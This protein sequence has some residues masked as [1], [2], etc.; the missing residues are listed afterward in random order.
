M[1]AFSG[2]A[3]AGKAKN[4]Q[5]RGMVGIKLGMEAVVFIDVLY[6]FLNAGNLTSNLRSGVC[7]MAAT[8][9]DDEAGADYR[10]KTCAWLQYGECVKTDVVLYAPAGHCSERDAD[11]AQR[12]H[13]ASRER[14]SEV[15]EGAAVHGSSDIDGG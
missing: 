10:T 6:L 7:L 15:L 3:A 4:R 8:A 2:T 1:E 11:V 12:C 14:V 5:R 9:H 13:G